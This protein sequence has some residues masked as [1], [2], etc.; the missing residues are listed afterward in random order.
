MISSAEEKLILMTAQEKVELLRLTVE[1]TVTTHVGLTRISLKVF[2][3]MPNA[4][5]KDN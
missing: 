5:M 2:T 1:K 4:E 3:K